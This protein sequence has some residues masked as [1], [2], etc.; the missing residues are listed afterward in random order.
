LVRLHWNAWD[1]S[2]LA[3]Y[4]DDDERHKPSDQSSAVKNSPAAKLC[5]E[6][7]NGVVREAITKVTGKEVENA[8]GNAD[9]NGS[10]AH[11]EAAK[12]Q[13]DDSSSNPSSTKVEGTGTPPTKEELKDE[14]YTLALLVLTA[15]ARVFGSHERGITDAFTVTSRGQNTDTMPTPRIIEGFLKVI[16]EKG[17]VISE[18]SVST[19]TYV[20]RSWSPRVTARVN[21]IFFD[22][23]SSHG[24]MVC[25]S[26]HRGGVLIT[27]SLSTVVG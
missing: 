17:T 4:T 25:G 24:S 10:Y 12:Q 8:G 22:G 16:L 20:H 15:W 2:D 5:V 11:A 19:S 6:T 27:L 21:V 26:S 9:Q 13:A 14:C 1:A 23:D 3:V 18:I 7:T